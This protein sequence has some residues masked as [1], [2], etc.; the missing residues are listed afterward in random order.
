MRHRYF[1][2]S[3]LTVSLF[4]GV[5]SKNSGQYYILLQLFFLHLPDALRSEVRAKAKRNKEPS[6]GIIDNQ[7]VKNE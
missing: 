1:P 2:H 4:S 7:S 6:V 3:R 5:Y